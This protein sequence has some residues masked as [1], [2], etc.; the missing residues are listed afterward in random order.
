VASLRHWRRHWLTRTIGTAPVPRKKE[1]RAARLAA[2]M[3]K[4]GHAGGPMS[5]S[6]VNGLGTS[7]PPDAAGDTLGLD[8][9][10]EAV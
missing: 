7:T 5:D 1:G 10:V 3:E 9:G 8:A 6:V 4:D 2:M